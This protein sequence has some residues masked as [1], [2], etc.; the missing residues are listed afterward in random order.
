M[1]HGRNWTQVTDATVALGHRSA[2]VAPALV[3]FSANNSFP[4]VLGS[5]SQPVYSDYLCPIDR[6]GTRI[7][8]RLKRFWDSD[9]ITA[10]SFSLRIGGF[11]PTYKR[12]SVTG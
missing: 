8:T 5:P 4:A 6:A 3:L 11:L 7:S 12:G 9:Y 10:G 2:A 1:A